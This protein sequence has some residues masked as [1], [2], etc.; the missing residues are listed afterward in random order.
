[1]IMYCNHCKRDL[2]ET[3]FSPSRRKLK[4][5]TCKDCENAKSADYT[6]SQI[7]NEE[8]ESNFDRLYGGYIVAILNHTR[9]NE[10]KYTIKG[11]NGIM[12]Q[13]NDIEYFR[14]KMDEIIS[15]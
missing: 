3:A 9:A 1:M 4:Y 2:P 10:Y 15:K 11:T 13:T 6:R 14:K 12:I 5:H 8:N 7:L